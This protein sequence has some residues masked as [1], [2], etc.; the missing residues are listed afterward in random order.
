[1]GFISR[2]ESVSGPMPMTRLELEEIYP[3]EGE[4][5]PINSVSILVY[6][7]KINEISSSL[8]DVIK[9]SKLKLPPVRIYDSDLSYK[10]PGRSWIAV[11]NDLI[12][13]FLFRDVSSVLNANE[14]LAVA[15]HEL[16][17]TVSGHKKTG[18]GN[19]RNVD[20][21]MEAD[22]FAVDSGID[23]KTLISAINKLAFQDE[24][25]VKRIVA[26]TQL[27]GI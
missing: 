12:L 8:N 22:K 9:R 15:I 24:E 13:I 17:H 25:K 10:A 5:V 3:E 11:N 20:Y 26:L 18:P 23:P 4:S 7:V 6:S 21:E 14:V 1:M 19:I 16:G 27:I 2:S